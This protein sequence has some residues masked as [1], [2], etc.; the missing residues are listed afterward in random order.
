MSRKM[1]ALCTVALFVAGAAVAG[2]M[3][4]FDM[5]NCA[6]CKGI[7][8][9]PEMMESITWEQH[10]ISN[11]V[12]AVTTVEMKYMDEYRKAHAMM[13][14]TVKRLQEGE[15]MELCGSCTALGACMAKGVNQEYVETTHG[16]VWI[17]T[18][19]KAEVVAELQNWAKRNTEEMAKM[20]AKS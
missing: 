1:I 6:M 12:V 17:V 8:S 20:K 4:W 18:S 2:D 14:E 5:D 16:D 13:G 19:E 7:S 3:A 10:N 11:G 9:H 15:K